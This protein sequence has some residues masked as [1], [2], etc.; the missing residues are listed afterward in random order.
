MLFLCRAREMQYCTKPNFQMG[1]GYTTKQTKP[2]RKL[3]ECVFC[4]K[5]LSNLMQSTIGHYCNHSKLTQ[6]FCIHCNVL[7]HPVYHTMLTW[8]VAIATQ[9]TQWYNESSHLS[10]RTSTISLYKRLMWNPVQ[11]SDT[12]QDLT[13][14]LADLK[15]C[16]DLQCFTKVIASVFIV[17]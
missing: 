7:H 13:F 5:K 2:R 9:F 1:A 16:H 4:K 6:K 12:N 17:H 3:S 8:F 11:G 15:G 14:I 10:M